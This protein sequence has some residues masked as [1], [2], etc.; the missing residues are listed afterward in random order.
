MLSVN[1]GWGAWSGWSSCTQTCDTGS[2][3]RSRSCNNPYP[4]YGGAGCSGTSSESTDCNTNNCPGNVLVWNVFDGLIWQC[5]V[6][7][8]RER[9]RD[10]NLYIHYN[11]YL[12]FRLVIWSAIEVNKYIM[13][14]T[15]LEYVGYR[16]RPIIR[17]Q[18]MQIQ[19]NSTNE[20]SRKHSDYFERM[21]ID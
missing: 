18:H 16:Y 19:F 2:K 7:Y 3:S 5:H 9:E 20:K 12:F 10:V 13:V 17:V 6:R 1:G 21:I 14:S 8:M 11:W 15:G 4:Q